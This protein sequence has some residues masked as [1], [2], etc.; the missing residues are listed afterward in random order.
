M[1]L[2]LQIGSI[3]LGPH[4]SV[5]FKSL[6]QS[7]AT[8]RQQAMSSTASVRLTEQSLRGLN[9]SASRGNSQS[10]LLDDRSIAER[11]INYM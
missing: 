5:I 8:A 10:N 4:N 11:S 3:V 6:S 1:T 2:N 9:K 7:E